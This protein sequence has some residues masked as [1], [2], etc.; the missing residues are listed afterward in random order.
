MATIRLFNKRSF[1]ICL[2][3]KWQF[4]NRNDPQGASG[5]DRPKVGAT[6]AVHETT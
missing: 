5:S 2:N 6:T 4:S 3:I 1:N